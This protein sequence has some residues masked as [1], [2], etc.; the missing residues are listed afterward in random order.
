MAA[1]PAQAPRY[2]IKVIS[3]GDNCVGKSCLIKRFCEGKFLQ[4]YISTIGV[5][6][7]VKPCNFGS[8][9]LKVNFFDLA[10]GDIY[11]DIRTE[12]Y[13]D[14]QGAFLVF[15]L[16]QRSSFDSLTR[17]VQEAIQ[18]NGG[19]LPVMVLVGNKNDMGRRVVSE[20][21]AREWMAQFG[22]RHYVETSAST[23]ANVHELFSTLF[24]QILELQQ[25]P[26]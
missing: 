3:M 20:Q 10:G 25:R 16:T 18:F 9:L 14:T 22:I 8:A 23:G 11:A 2:R 26:P 1:P 4:K 21:E 13:R 5:D 6:F 24:Q 7:G 12:F 17:W 19:P 15:D